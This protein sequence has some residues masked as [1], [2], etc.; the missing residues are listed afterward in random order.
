MAHPSY[1]TLSATDLVEEFSAMARD[2]EMVFGRYDATQLNWQPQ[3]GRWS[4]AQCFD[5]LLK[6]ADGMFLTFDRALDPNVAPTVWQRLPMWPRMLGRALITSQAPGGKRKYRAPA[7]AQPAGSSLDPLTVERFIACQHLG[8][9]RLRALGAEDA[10][11]IA[12][13][14]FVAQITY[15]VLDGYRL[16]AA[17]QRRHFDQARRVIEHPAFPSTWPAP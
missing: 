11:R 15:S 16:I 8:I 7:T 5:H 3:A 1:A 6:T 9:A 12:V 14:P 2:T 4:V 13:S 17:H 10:R